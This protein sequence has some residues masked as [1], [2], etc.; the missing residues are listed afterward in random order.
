[1][2]QPLDVFG[3]RIWKNW[4]KKYSD[5][6]RIKKVD[7]SLQTRNQM[8]KLQSIVHDQ[9]S[10]PRFVNMWKYSWYSSGYKTERPEPF[11]NPVDFTFKFRVEETCDCGRV[12]FAR[13]GWCE[14][15]LCFECFYNPSD[16]YT[17][18]FHGI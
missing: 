18:H 9:L 13:C 16:D 4:V 10:A 8:L 17:Y 11:E 1:M 15:H 6:V 2:I 14:R 12:P 5:Y 7:V 3:F